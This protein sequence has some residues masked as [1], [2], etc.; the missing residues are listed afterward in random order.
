TQI[1]IG[2]IA[3]DVAEIVPEV[4]RQSGDYLAIRYGQ[5]T[6][7]NIEA[8]KEIDKTIETLRVGDS[9]IDAILSASST[10]LIPTDDAEGFFSRILSAMG[11]W[12][13]DGILSFERL[14]AYEFDADTVRAREITASELLCVGETCVTE[15]E[16]KA[17]LEEDS[18]TSGTQTTGGSSDTT[19]DSQESTDSDDT[20][21]TTESDDTSSST[22]DSSTTDTTD[23]TATSTDDGSTDD[24]TSSTDSTTDDTDTT[25]SDTSTSTDDTS[26]DDTTDT[27]DESTDTTSDSTTDTTDDT[28]TTDDG[29]TETSTDTSTS[30]DEV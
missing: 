18:I 17:L 25:S 14:Y 11:A 20:T 27:T 23:D 19:D 6:A 8:I 21:T 22:D 26:T 29:S 13:E 24:T 5:L 2:L 7:L 1:E 15:D 12:I 4:V 28:S 3:Q 30:T 9:E 16:L 10:D